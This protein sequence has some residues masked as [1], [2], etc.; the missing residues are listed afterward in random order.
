MTCVSFSFFFLFFLYL[1]F[2]LFCLRVTFCAL[3]I[4][5]TNLALQSCQGKVMLLSI[6]TC[7]MG[8][9]KIRY[10]LHVTKYMYQ[11]N[12]NSE[13][14][15]WEMGSKTLKRKKDELYNRSTFVTKRTK[16]YRIQPWPALT[17]SNGL[18]A[19]VIMS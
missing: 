2:Q 6:T 4:R 17:S 8:T 14:L 12:E 5:N 3:G 16:F 13:R 9:P 1:F 18:P 10:F 15:G 19:A 11:R 7:L